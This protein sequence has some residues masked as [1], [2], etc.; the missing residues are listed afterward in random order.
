[1]D[2]SPPFLSFDTDSL[3]SQPEFEEM[4]QDFMNG[5]TDN[6]FQFEEMENPQPNLPYCSMEEETSMFRVGSPI[7]WIEVF[8]S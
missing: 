5:S 4:S 8:D 2:I 6:L 7:N 3:Q 1:M